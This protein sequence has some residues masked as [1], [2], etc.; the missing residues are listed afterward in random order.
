MESALRTS[1]RE[2]GA[3]SSVIS[4]RLTTT[5]NRSDLVRSLQMASPSLSRPQTQETFRGASRICSRQA[6][7]PTIASRCDKGNLCVFVRLRSSQI[8][9]D[10]L[11]S[12]EI[13]SRRPIATILTLS[14]SPAFSK[15][16]PFPDAW[17]LR[18]RGAFSGIDSMLFCRKK[19]H[20]PGLT[21]PYRTWPD[22]TRHDLIPEALSR[23]PTTF[24]GCK[25][26]DTASIAHFGLQ[27]ALRPDRSTDRGGPICPSRRHTSR[28]RKQAG[29]TAELLGFFL[30][31]YCT[32]CYRFTNLQVSSETSISGPIR[33]ALVE[34]TPRP[35]A[36]YPPPPTVHS[37]NYF[38]SPA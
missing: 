16:L 15:D 32:M 12:S 29:G 20:C 33:H 13:V 10:R 14:L 9:S 31:A 35:H 21:G 17:L 25:R 8:V 11:R 19:W 23:A 28:S 7:M 5:P 34:R 30:A 38:G 18:F 36:G 6:R 37:E 27:M 4:R 2:T 1:K 3:S 22:L 24:H 26:Q